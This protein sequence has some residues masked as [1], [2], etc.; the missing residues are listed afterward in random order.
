MLL[1]LDYIDVFAV[2]DTV[3]D[4]YISYRQVAAVNNDVRVVSLER[5]TANALVVVNNQTRTLNSL[6]K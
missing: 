1:D 4:K 3:D 2:C 5:A 6:L